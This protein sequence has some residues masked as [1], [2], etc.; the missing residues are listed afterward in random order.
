MKKLKNMKM[1]VTLFLAILL[2]FAVAAIMGGWVFYTIM[3][4]AEMGTSFLL[5]S[6]MQVV[7]TVLTIFFA[8]KMA[9]YAEKAIIK[10]EQKN[11][12]Y[13]TILD[14]ASFPIH[15]TDNDMKWV[16]MNKA[17][18]KL[19]VDTGAIKDRESA[20]GK[21]CSNAHANICNTE[22]C[23]I[24]QLLHKGDGISYFDWCGSECKQ[25]TTRLVSETGENLGYVEIVTDLTALIRANT[26]NKESIE[27][28]NENLNKMAAGNLDLNLETRPA[29]EFTKEEHKNFETINSNLA[30][31]KEALAG[32]IEDTELLCDAAVAGKLNTR[33]DVSRHEGEYR[34]I[35]NGIN[36]I[37]DAIV[38]PLNTSIEFIRKMSDGE[39]MGTIDNVYQGDYKVLIDDINNVRNTLS[40]LI[41]ESE[42]LAEAGIRGD[43]TVRGDSSK[44]PGQYTEIVGGFNKMLDAIAAPVTEADHVLAKMSVN[45]YTTQ[46]TG[47]Y[48]GMMKKLAESIN[49]VRAR[50]LSIENVFISVSKGNTDQLDTFKQIGKRSE[51]DNIMPAAIGMMQA[52]NDLIVESNNLAQAAV[53]GDLDERGDIGKFEGGYREII[54]GMNHTMEAMQKPIHESS[55]VLSKLA[56]GDLTVSMDGDYS[57]EYADIKSSLNDAI[58][59]F[60][61]VLSEINIAAS[62]VSSGSRQ[63]S[64]GSQALSQGATEQASS[65]EELTASITEIAEQTK[66]NAV[67]AGKANEISGTVKTDAIRGN[68]QMQE[69]LHS[70]QEINES[71]LNISKIIKVIDDIA[72]QTNILALNAAVEAARA[73]QAGKGFAVV[74][75]EVKSLAA[76]SANAAKETTALIEGSVKKVETGTDIANN[77]AEALKKIV[78]GV[79]KTANLVGEIA[80]ASNEQATGIAQI[81]KGIEQVSQVVQTNSATAEQSAAASEELSGQASLLQEMVGKF[82]LKAG[83]TDKKAQKSEKQINIKK[84]NAIPK[85][86][87]S[88]GSFGKY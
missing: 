70:M 28:L 60:N 40:I 23:G 65:I 56:D 59:S 73:G 30:K 52:I 68:D 19:L 21:D 49:D 82:S 86:K 12:W 3:H 62:Q 78:S 67:N 61:K 55:S 51:N 75:N 83:D 88:E 80:N 15:V 33:A 22:K 31:V 17:F 27:Q 11:N 46:I 6:A 29:D 37:L 5:I 32:M 7:P 58:E 53:N 84:E 16:F 76:K 79:E 43:L 14:A 38:N 50:M 26:Y 69:M 85:I 44:L 81:N 42:K 64:D 72:F 4:S 47:N 74:A 57:G 54:Q 87:L 77:T 2:I 8:W 63:V 71:S 9:K 41:S 25:E 1:Q 45:D 66:H 20:Y 39:D 18:E 34:Q 36:K 13:K 10:L 48:T 35:V 24:K